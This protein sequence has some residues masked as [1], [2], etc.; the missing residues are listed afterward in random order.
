PITAPASGTLAGWR[1]T[2]GSALRKDQTIGSI[3]IQG[4]YGQSLKVIRAPAEGTVGL[5]NVVDGVFVTAGTQLA[6]AYDLS[7]IFVTARLDETTIRDVRHGQRVDIAVDA[8]SHI[9]FTGY[10]WEIQGGAAGLFSRSSQDNT[11]GSF[12]KLT[13]WIPVKIAIADRGDL[14]LVPG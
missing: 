4:G 14:T 7:K 2:H 5:D 9:T 10:V 11:S 8:Y 13:Q 3:Q 6:V 1:A 12:Q